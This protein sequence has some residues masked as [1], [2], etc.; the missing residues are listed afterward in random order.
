MFV[1]PDAE[2]DD[3]QF[4]VVTIGEIGKLRY[5]GNLP[6]VFK[7]THVEDDE[8]DRLPRRRASSSAPAGPS[9][10]TPTAST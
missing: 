10:S 3:G 7:G 2:L 1:A 6:K 8:V 4:D 9:P 5:V